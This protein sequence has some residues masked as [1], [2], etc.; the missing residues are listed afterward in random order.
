MTRA[1]SILCTLFLVAGTR[2]NAQT[3][4]SEPLVIDTPSNVTQC[5]VT[6]ITWSGGLPPYT[7]LFNSLDATM[8]AGGNLA[9]GTFNTSILWTVA[10]PEGQGLFLSVFDFGVSFA[11]NDVSCLPPSE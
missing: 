7:V 10:E 5:G 3:Q 6:N 9:A 8:P 4:P 2:T 11:T 1:L